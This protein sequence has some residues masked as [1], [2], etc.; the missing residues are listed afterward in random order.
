MNRID[1]ALNEFF[2]EASTLT[3]N[4]KFYNLQQ[5]YMWNALDAMRRIQEFGK[6]A[7]ESKD[8]EFKQVEGMKQFKILEKMYMS[9][10]K[11]NKLKGIS[12]SETNKGFM[13]KIKQHK[14]SI[15]DIV[16]DSK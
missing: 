1:E 9:Q 8:E 11:S 4:E 13:E 7:P 3:F 2:D 5:A 6:E 15:G 14:D 12:E 16:R 10:L